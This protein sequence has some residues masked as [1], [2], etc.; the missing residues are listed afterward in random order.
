MNNLYNKKIL[1][2]INNLSRGG[3]ERQKE[4]I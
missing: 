1:F 4:Y 2:V 3:A